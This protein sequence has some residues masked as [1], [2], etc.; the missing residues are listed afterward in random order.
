VK[1]IFISPSELISGMKIA[2]TILNEY[3]AII[4]SEGT[5]LD[6]H[7]V[8]KLKK[9]GLFRLQVFEQEN[10]ETEYKDEFIKSYNSSVDEYKKII[11]DIAN[12]A[13]LNT[14]KIDNVVDSVLQR[15]EEKRDIISCLN[16]IRSADEYTYAHSINVSLISMLIGNWMKFDSGRVRLLVQAGMLHDIGKTM[17]PIE[18]L[19]K[20]GKLTAEEFEEIKKH[21][22]YGY[23]IVEKV[24]SVSKEVLSAVLMHH[25]KEDGTGYPN[26]LSGDKIHIF[27]QIVS[28]ADI[29][30]A[31]T[32]NR[33]YREKDCPFDVFQL[34]E[35]NSLGKLNPT[36]VFAFL[37]NMAAYYI[38][39]K[40]RLSNDEI[41]E[42]IYI[43]P[44]VVSKPIVKVGD[45]FIDFLKEKDIKIKQM[46]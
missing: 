12:G 42:I 45:K 27:A 30:D 5:I 6:D 4:I 21:P 29:Y 24:P 35:E 3:G 34:M 8:N 44:R 36:V 15:F 22:V 39:D 25:E 31:M 37:N 10:H 9:M 2:E 40:V 13:D 28:V 46:L 20:P 17:V 19:N 7:L 16:Q 38:G 33:V 23:R 26:K 41:G 11:T 18:I 43:N 14:E 32:S 1:K